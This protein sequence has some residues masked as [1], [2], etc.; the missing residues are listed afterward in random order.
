[1][2]IFP[3]PSSIDSENVAADEQKI[4]C[5]EHAHR[6]KNSIQRWKNKALAEDGMPIENKSYHCDRVP[7][8]KTMEK[9]VLC[10]QLKI[11]VKFHPS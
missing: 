10:L 6:T 5:Q 4:P 3:E 9:Q 7:K 1:M 8:L 11:E 2:Y